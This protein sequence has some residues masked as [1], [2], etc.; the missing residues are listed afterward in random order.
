M[1]I[2]TKNPSSFR[3]SLEFFGTGNNPMSGFIHSVIRPKV[4]FVGGTHPMRTFSDFAIVLGDDVAGTVSREIHAQ[5][6]NQMGSSG[7]FRIM[8]DHLGK[9]EY[10]IL[11]SEVYSGCTVSSYTRSD[12]YERTA[13]SHAISLFGTP[14]SYPSL[15]TLEINCKS[16]D[17]AWPDA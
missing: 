15:F 7:N 3:T 13:A 1:P 9:D 10:D 6:D 11:E 5:M 16:M 14:A 2:T 4:T 8:I 12:L 17:V